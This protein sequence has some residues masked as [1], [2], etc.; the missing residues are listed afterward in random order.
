[1][2]LA[3]MPFLRRLLQWRQFCLMTCTFYL[4]AKSAA[5]YSEHYSSD[6][7][8]V[9]AEDFCLKKRGALLAETL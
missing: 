6:R 2:V 7:L 9:K 5:S 1:M 3:V 8:W 4:E